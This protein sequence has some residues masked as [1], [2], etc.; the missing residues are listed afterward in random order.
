M[1]ALVVEVGA[2]NVQDLQVELFG[3]SLSNIGL[4]D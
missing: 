3:I 1:K 4:V 2:G